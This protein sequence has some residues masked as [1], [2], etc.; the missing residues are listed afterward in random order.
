MAE[1]KDPSAVDAP[2][3]G[4]R[5]FL[6]AAAVAPVAA[7]AATLSTTACEVSVSGR[8]G[9]VSP[10]APTTVVEPAAPSEAVAA[11]RRFALARDVEPAIAFRPLI[12]TAGARD[13]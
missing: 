5:A 4:R 11:V 12:P 7:I 10:T 13:L 1:R 2:R 9:A 6:G 3:S 8:A